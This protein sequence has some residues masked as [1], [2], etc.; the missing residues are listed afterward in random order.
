[1]TARPKRIS[2]D[3]TLEGLL[4]SVNPHVPYQGVFLGK[5]LPARVALK[6]FFPCVRSFVNHALAPLCEPLV[7]GTTL[8][9]LLSRVG[10]VMNLQ[11]SASDESLAT[12]VTLVGPFPIVASLVDGQMRCLCKGLVAHETTERLFTR[13]YPFVDI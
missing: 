1:M 5:R 2:T 10:P 12:Q 4:T 8:K 6:Q 7:A 3:A 11:A 9:G 13:V